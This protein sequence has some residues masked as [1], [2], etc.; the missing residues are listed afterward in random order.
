MLKEWKMLNLQICIY[1]FNLWIYPWLTCPTIQVMKT[2]NIYSQ[3]FF[4]YKLYKLVLLIFCSACSIITYFNLNNDHSCCC[5]LSSMLRKV[6][7]LNFLWNRMNTL[8]LVCFLS[9]AHLFSSLVYYDLFRP[10]LF[11]TFVDSSLLLGV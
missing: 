4:F 6:R 10:F 7:V 9:K 8:F 2:R 1:G 3:S 11:K 5:S